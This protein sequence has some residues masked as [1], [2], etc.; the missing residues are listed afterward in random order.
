MTGA[1]AGSWYA[2]I[3]GAQDPRLMPLVQSCADH[4]C[5]ISGDLDPDLAPALPWLVRLDPAERLTQ[6]W[7]DHGQGRHW[8]VTLQSPLDLLHVKLQLKKF[9]NAR[10]PDGAT[11]LFRFYD[12]R[13]FRTYLR[14][15]TPGERLPWFN[16][17]GRYSVES[18]TPGHYHDFTL[19]G[20]QLFDHAQ[21]VAGATV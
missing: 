6:V 10:L 1:E 9:L 17:I 20:G 7:R 5:L 11:V 4:A 8:G 12:P 14:A 3:D 15:A 21:L 19:Q 16:G 18:E 2:V 13:V